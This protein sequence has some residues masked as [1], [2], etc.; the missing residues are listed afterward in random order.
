MMKEAELREQL[1]FNQ[2]ALDVVM[3][4]DRVR[5]VSPG[6]GAI[7]S[8]LAHVM[9][10]HFHVDACL[11]YVMDR[12]AHTYDLK[13]VQE[14]DSAWRDTAQA[15]SET[16][17]REAMR[18]GEISLWEAVDVLPPDMVSKLPPTFRMVALPVFLDEKP[19]GLI[20]MARNAP[21]FDEQEIQLMHIAESQIDSA[22]IQAYVH[23]DLTQRNK[24]LET[25]YNFDRIRDRY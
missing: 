18:E 10:D 8:G 6:P 25:I 4:I 23:H 24:E 13:V 2:K 17:I 5:D 12:E 15:L 1:A 11:L 9:C 21:V 3:S 20:L 19:L 14:R 7:F 16:R 22:I